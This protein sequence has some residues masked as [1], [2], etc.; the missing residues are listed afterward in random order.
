MHIQIS[1]NATISK[2]ITF[3]QKLKWISVKSNETE[4]NLYSK[5]KLKSEAKSRTEWNAKDKRKTEWNNIV[6]L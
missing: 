4:I 1:S 2:Y 6:I 3:F 5:T